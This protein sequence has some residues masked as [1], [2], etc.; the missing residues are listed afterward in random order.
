[1]KRFAIL[2]AMSGIAAAPCSAAPDQAVETPAITAALIGPAQV[3]TE[4]VETW[5]DVIARIAVAGDVVTNPKARNGAQGSWVVPSDRS[6]YERA[7]SGE[8]YVTN[9]W[10]DT[11]MGI[12]FDGVVTFEG[13]SFG[14]Q[15]AGAGVWAA[16]VRVLGYLD[17]KLVGETEWSKPLTERP[18]WVPAALAGVDRIVIEARPVHQG[19][20][21]FAMDDVTFS[22]DGTKTVVTFDDLG[23][24]TKLR[25]SKYAGLSWETGTGDFK[26]DADWAMPAPKVLANDEIS[27]IGV[28]EEPQLELR[29]VAPPPT[30]LQLLTFQGPK[31]GDFGTGSFPPDTCGAIG[32][33][34]FVSVVNTIFAVYDR[35]AGGLVTGSTLNSFQPGT[36]GD[37]RVMYDAVDDRWIVVSTNFST[38][39]FVAYSLTN[40]PTGAW[41]KFSFNASTGTNAGCNVDYPTLGYDDR[42]I[43]IGA[44]MFNSC[45]MS[46][47]AIDKA[48]LLAGSPSV[49]NIWAF[50]QLPSF[51]TTQPCV[52]L[53]VQPGEAYA[54]ARASSSQIRK[55]TLTGPLN[56]GT[57]PTL[58][59]IIVPIAVHSSPPDAPASGAGTPLDTVGSRLMNA[60]YRDGK[61]WTAH[62]INIGGRAAARWYEIGTATNS[63]AQFGTISDP[64]FYYY[65][66]TLSVNSVGAM[67]IGFSGSH[68][69][70]FA[71][72]FYA[73]R[74][75]FDPLGATSIPF[76]YKVGEASQNLIDGFGR[77]RWGDY[78]LVTI[79]PNDD[80]GFWC[81]QE[82]S[83]SPSNIWGTWVAQL[84]Y[85]NDCN[86]NGIDDLLDIGSGFSLDING[87]SVPDECEPFPD[88]FTLTSPADLATGIDATINFNML[89]TASNPGVNY[90]VRISENADLSLPT[91]D[92]AA[93]SGFF[94]VPGGTLAGNTTYFWGVTATDTQLRSTD[95]TPF[96]ISF[97]TA[98]IP[99]DCTGDSDGDGAV[100]LNDLNIVLFSFGAVVT[101]GTSGDIDGDGTVTLNDLNIVL[102]N[103]GNVC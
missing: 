99:G 19:A 74:R 7:S 26:T 70:V 81:I 31:R 66:P 59:N 52:H 43:Y 2:A 71:G 47:F 6:T 30:P 44:F 98:V 39:I 54:V 58:S 86:N 97:T 32:P 53:G 42:G 76:E 94:L 50:R 18:I 48:S 11:R 89:W 49:G 14:G 8:R 62:A 36:S 15:G 41:F 80:L 85:D 64:T 95:S 82:Y 72:A 88:P 34:H 69:S 3:T 103:F 61:I 16:G 4:G 96:S 20:G 27:P 67:V 29:G 23:P 25:D 9:K 13:A 77:N 101:P 46:L 5:D 21:F 35:S 87:N 79:D 45:G 33:N 78:S 24:A 57:A 73:G 100:T 51:A 84:S 28:F 38:S 90:Q 10:G 22:R 1:M 68:A 12:S 63:V 56:T 60:V 92:A 91:I 93:P 75:A 17:G 40:D 37:P 83:E 65:D 102:F 55:Y